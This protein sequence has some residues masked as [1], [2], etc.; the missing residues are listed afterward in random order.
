MS[1]RCGAVVPLGLCS[2][3]AHV[4][5]EAQVPCT[6]QRVYWC[7]EDAPARFW[8]ADVDVQNRVELFRLG[9]IDIHAT[10]P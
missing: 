8:R 2:Y 4:I 1:L 3:P 7:E 9:D 10:A 5:D 6:A